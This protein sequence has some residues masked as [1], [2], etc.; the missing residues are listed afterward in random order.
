MLFGF[1][2]SNCLLCPIGADS[3][4]HLT[5]DALP[6]RLAGLWDWWVGEIALEYEFGR[7][8]D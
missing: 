2:R 8:D 4:G 5:F 1:Q 6:L 7:E 3:S